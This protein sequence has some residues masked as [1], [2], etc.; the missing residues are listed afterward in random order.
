M[1]TELIQIAV[2]DYDV[3]NEGFHSGVFLRDVTAQAA[4]REYLP[5][6][7]ADAARSWTG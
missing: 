3:T 6:L 2:G 7:D 5:L 1:A 4:D